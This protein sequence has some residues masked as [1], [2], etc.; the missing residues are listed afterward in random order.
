[1]SWRV[2][3]T[4][5]RISEEDVEAVLD[6][7]RSGW[8]TMGPRTIAFEEAFAEA[9]GAAHAVA[10]SSCTAALHLACVAA[11]F[12]PG[13]EVVVPGLTFV[14]T[15]NAVRYVGATPVLCEVGGPTDLNLDVADVERRLTPRTKG[16]IA[17][18]F[19]GY[20]AAMDDLRA[21]CDARGLRLIEDCAHAMTATVDAA[22]RH[23]GTVG[24]LGCFSLFSKKQLS[25]GEGGVV[26]SGDE[27]LAA[28][29]RSLRAHAM[30][31]VTWDRHR[32][33]GETYDV[34]DVGFNYRIDEPRAAL[35][36][37]RL[38]RVAA[39]VE[40]RREIVREYRSALRDADGLELAWSDEDVERSAHFAF[41][42]V[43]RDR[44]ARDAFRTELHGAGVQT[45]WYPA[46]HRFTEYRELDPELAL[47]QV[48]AAAERHCAIPLSSSMTSDDVR[49]V[50]GAVR[51]ALDAPAVPSR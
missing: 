38:P 2:P 1:M 11:G 8:L 42:V 51:A 34:T 16:V 23:A 26:T 50:V 6:C 12:G 29:V 5:V 27:E 45:T 36:L 9:T 31:R 21:L 20:P 10:V 49:V 18:H 24:D 19:C 39:S 3:L 32:G 47:P 40:R 22:G 44:A 46:V 35:A 14:S 7:L 25:V 4:D 30:T 48:E 15:A 43:L 28:R 17:V 33:Y 13:D 37:S 41:P